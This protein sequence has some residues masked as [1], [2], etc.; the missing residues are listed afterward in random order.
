MKIERVG[1]GFAEIVGGQ[2][3]D[4]SEVRWGLP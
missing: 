1:D 3:G 2:G 4:H